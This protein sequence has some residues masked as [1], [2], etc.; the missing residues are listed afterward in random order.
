MREFVILAALMNTRRPVSISS[1]RPQPGPGG[2]VTED[3]EWLLFTGCSSC[4]GHDYN[5]SCKTGSCN[6]DPRGPG[7]WRGFAYKCGCP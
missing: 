7:Q 1:S 3:I 5:S 6:G 2:T 4:G